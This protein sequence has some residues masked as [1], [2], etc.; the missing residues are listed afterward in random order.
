LNGAKAISSKN[1]YSYDNREIFDLILK[2]SIIQ[3]KDIKNHLLTF[4][5]DEIHSNFSNEDFIKYYNIYKQVVVDTSII[6]YMDKKYLT[7]F[8]DYNKETSNV[9]VIN[10]EKHTLNLKDILDKNK[11]KVIYID[12][13]ASWCAPCRSVMPDSRNLHKH[14]LK[15]D[16][17]FIYIS[18]DKD[19]EKWK[20]ASLEENISFLEYNLLSINYPIADFYKKIN[21]KSIPRYLL[22]DKK[23]ELVRQKAPSPC[24]LP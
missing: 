15:K 23:G 7:E 19:F 24:S 22:F 13:W 3:N 5:L 4:M 2:D 12:F 1:G 14:F 18:I 6:S 9:F 8:L 21:L 20:N 17:L 11:G 10:Q 16:V